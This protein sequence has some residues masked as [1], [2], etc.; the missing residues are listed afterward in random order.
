MK[1]I[2]T[3]AQFSAC[4]QY[5]YRLSRTWSNGPTVLWL[6]LN[7]STADATANDPTVE[8]CERRA[9]ASGYGRLL[10]ANIFALRST[11]PK[12]LYTH[13]EP[14][15]PDNDQAISDT[16]KQADLVVCGWGNHGAL[17]GRGIDVMRSLESAD[18]N[19]HA[20]RMTGAGQ[21]NHPLYVP[22]AVE[23]R[24]ITEL[25]AEAV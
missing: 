2:D 4:G 15:G 25:L 19:P 16:A 14:I 20:L 7:P 21:P 17:S 6:M 3:D 1:Y 9:R 24:P 5:R 11:D 8:R 10:V 12:G 18:L 22:Y 23:P 13:D